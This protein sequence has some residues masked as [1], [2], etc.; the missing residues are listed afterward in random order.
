MV[1]G[2]TETSYAKDEKE[3]TLERFLCRGGIRC[4]NFRWFIVDV[5]GL[6]WHGKS[7]RQNMH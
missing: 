3:F 2:L 5:I 6:L 1:H 7:L 4:S